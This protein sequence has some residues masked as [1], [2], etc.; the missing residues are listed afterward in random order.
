[1]ANSAIQSMQS[2]DRFLQEVAATEKMA[3]EAH[4]EPGS[5]G[6]PTQHP[7]KDVDD[8]TEEASEGFRSAENDADVKEDQGPPSVDNTPENVAAKKAMDGKSESGSVNPP[9]TAAEDQLQIG[10]KKEPTGQDPSVETSSVKAE[11][12]DPSSAPDGS[13]GHSSHP[14]RTNNSELDGYKYAEMDLDRLA[15]VASDLGNSLLAGLAKE[16]N[17]CDSG[18]KSG[19]SCGKP[20]CP[21]CKEKKAAELKGDQHKLDVNNDGKIEGSDLKAL[22]AGEDAGEDQED[23]SKSATDLAGQAGWDLAGLASGEFDEKAAHALVKRELVDAI[24]QANDMADMTAEFVLAYQDEM[25]KKAMGEMPAGVDPAALMGGEA[26]EMPVEAGP[27]A[28]MAA[29]MAGGDMP[30]GGDDVEQLA[31]VLDSLGISPEELE[32]AMAAQDGGDMAPEGGDEVVEESAMEETADEA[33]GMEVEASHKEAAAK[34]GA[35]EKTTRDYIQEVL[36]R[37]RRR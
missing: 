31:A 23:D 4:T 24:K 7:V 3:A 29:E 8:S 10:T 15:K 26:G 20:G 25:S 9:G 6:G 27:E 5:V 17:N 12:E 1:M 34:K 36:E 18:G 22:R 2:I 33:P 28:D 21:S 13:V 11:K 37:S 19:C 32:A 14:A 16:A 35:A 30:E